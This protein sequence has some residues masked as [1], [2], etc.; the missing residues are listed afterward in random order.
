M[1]MFEEARAMQ[2]TIELCHMTQSQLAK[3]LGVTQS[4]VANKLRLL[5]L[6]TKVQNKIII[7]NVNERIARTLLQLDD[8]ECQLEVLDK[9]ITH[10]LTVRE[11]EAMVNVRLLGTVKKLAERSD[12]SEHID[13]F[14]RMLKDSVDTL[15]SLG[16]DAKE[17]VSIQGK[18]LYITVCINGI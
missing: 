18:K 6:G 3:S 11:C 16:I 15:I 5:K 10:S 4:Y 14:T 13:V 9:V 1:N 7:N 2:G 8:E 12:N 17:R